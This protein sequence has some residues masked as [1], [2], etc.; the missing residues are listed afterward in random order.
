MVLFVSTQVCSSRGLT[1]VLAIT[2]AV[3]LCDLASPQ[4]VGRGSWVIVAPLSAMA[5]WRSAATRAE[6]RS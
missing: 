4:T 1:L 2:F 3:G 5:R 6:T